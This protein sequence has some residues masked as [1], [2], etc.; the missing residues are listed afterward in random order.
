MLKRGQNMAQDRMITAIGR[1][2]NALSRLEKSVRSLPAL[3]TEGGVHH[4]HEQLK[5][6]TRAILLDL[7]QLLAGASR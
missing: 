5:D 6:E 7:D 1:I 3:P 2:E 4:R